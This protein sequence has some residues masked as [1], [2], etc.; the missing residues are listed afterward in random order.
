MGCV[1]PCTL[2]CDSTEKGWR[3]PFSVLSQRPETRGGIH[4]VRL[5]LHKLENILVFND[6]NNY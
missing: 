6:L 1:Q 2:Y 4:D 5:F 3:H